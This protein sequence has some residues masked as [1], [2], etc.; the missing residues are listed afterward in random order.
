MSDKTRK[1]CENTGDTR[2]LNANF[3]IE[4]RKHWR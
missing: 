1:L 3:S 4:A 2:N